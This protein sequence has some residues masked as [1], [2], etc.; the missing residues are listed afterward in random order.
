M[1]SVTTV[2][3]RFENSLVQRM[4]ALTLLVLS[5]ARSVE[6]VCSCAVEAF[7][8]SSFIRML[9]KIVGQEHFDNAI[10]WYLSE[11][12]YGNADEKDLYDALERFTPDDVVGADGYPL[13]LDEFARCWTDQNGYPTLHVEKTSWGT[14]RLTQQI[15][16]FREEGYRNGSACG[17]RWDILIWYQES[18][19][20]ETK[21]MWFG[22]EQFNLE[23]ETNKTLIF[24]ADSNGFYKVS[25]SNELL[26]EI[27]SALESS[28]LLLSNST[29]YRIV[30]DVN[31]I[32]INDLGNVKNVFRI[33]KVLS[34]DPNKVIADY[35]AIA[36]LSARK[37]MKSELC[38]DKNSNVINV[39][40]TANSL[41]I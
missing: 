25:Y 8:G 30:R 31:E 3:L 29:K 9:A 28:K 10:R 14:F 1:D 19:S 13:N 26:S 32:S 24:N 21:F 15:D 17:Y 11:H 12:Q 4:A 36:L 23:L 6:N 39:S 16:K 37:W 33:A 20:E 35:A 27:A 38:A 7:Q 34:Q 5:T 41:N 22:K 18:G 40:K 2:S